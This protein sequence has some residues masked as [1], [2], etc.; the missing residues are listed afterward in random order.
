MSK[1]KV[2]KVLLE[3]LVFGFTEHVVNINNGWYDPNTECFVFDI[4]GQD[5]PE[6]CNKLNVIV[7]EQVNRAGQRLIT[8]KF[9][10]KEEKV[11]K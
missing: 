1:V 6:N 11:G 2:S 7:S 3:D 10:G 5:V 4:S 9:E 8:M